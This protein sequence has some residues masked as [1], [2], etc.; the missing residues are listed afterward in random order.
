VSADRFQRVESIFH[1]L[2]RLAPVERAAALDRLCGGDESLRAEVE[3][4]CAAHDRDEREPVMAG[5][6]L[7]P[8][9][10]LENAVASPGDPAPTR[11]G[12]YR[13]V[14]PLGAG[15]MGV[16]YLAIQ[17]G[18]GARVALKL[19]RAELSSPAILRRFER[20]ARV[21]GLLRHP[22]I[23]QVHE[24]GV[25]RAAPGERGVPFIAMELVDGAPLTSYLAGA[26]PDLAARLDLFARICDAVE[27]AH[28]QGV[29]HRDL[30]PGNILVDASGPLPQPKILDFGI[31]RAVG[32]DLQ[33]TTLA[34]DAGQL[35]GTLPYMSPE[36]AGGDPSRLDARSDV[37]ALGVI[38]Y[39]MLTGR[40]P[41]DLAGLRLA[42]AA[43]VVEETDPTPP[44]AIS[45]MYRGDLSTILVKALEKDP[46]RRYQ[47]ARELAADVRRHLAH[48]PIAA[49]PP[50]AWYQARKF[51]RRHRAI[52]ASGAV[53]LV[54]LVGAMAAVSA[55]AIDAA[56]ARDRAQHRFDDVRALARTF[57]F[58]LDGRLRDVPGTLSARQEIVSTGLRYL[59]RLA[60]EA[61]AEPSLALEVAQGYVRLSEVQG[62]HWHANVGDTHGAFTSLERARAILEDLERAQPAAATL[63]LVET[64]ARLGRLCIE[65]GRLDDARRHV[66]VAITR[67]GALGGGAEEAAALPWLS[68]A[69]LGL[70]II[71]R[72]HG[73]REEGIRAWE[74]SH[75]LLERQVAAATDD[76]A[77]R[78]ELA[79]S[80][81][82]RGMFDV[83]AAR[84]E[85]ALAA[86][87]RF[88][89]E[90]EAL[91]AADPASARHEADL[92]TGRERMGE[93]LARLGRHDEAL[94][95]CR[96]ALAIALR[97]AA[98]A[99]D[100]ADALARVSVLCTRAG[101]S[102]MALGRHAAAREAFERGL[103]A[104]RRRAERDERSPG[105]Q[106]ELAVAYYKL[107]EVAEAMSA[108]PDRPIAERRAELIAAR[109][110]FARCGEQ[111][112]EIV[113]RGLLLPGDDGVTA[114]IAAD[115]AR[116][117]AALVA[118]GP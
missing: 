114:A 41:Y 45:R 9:F 31:A 4:L 97:R 95:N 100:D 11:I 42:E 94:T 36:Q 8:D 49:H 105:A 55:A 69:L 46:A 101:E 72:A 88:T 102:E 107:A 80:W 65:L 110:W 51:A 112:A 10:A 71:E 28:R 27:H 44:S 26:E 92:I 29:I 86:M 52:V 106:R 85:D 111:F 23:A 39:E 54:L 5:P 61:A 75:E 81:F 82:Q 109:D 16:A 24:A 93:A 77:L 96:A 13:I 70:A 113:R 32:A 20:E 62:G 2:R 118:P 98:V 90:I 76:P 12:R 34:T 91:A 116:C 19:V 59:D 68:R 50:S 53:I 7:G 83:A 74:R 22:G 57:I 48:E 73:R 60:A 1:A 15:G 108:D 43:R 6:A 30:K 17:D 3:S 33:L 89:S 78:R 63:M 104:A 103:E 47:S 40:L 37:Y 38:L 18:T 35:V 99:P 79:V 14:R 58:D 64:H 115:V 25:H 21:L 56:R 66:G 84:W 87:T 117:D 67:A